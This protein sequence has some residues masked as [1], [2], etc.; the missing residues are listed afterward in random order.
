MLQRQNGRLPLYAS[1]FS[2]LR[3][4]PLRGWPTW[5]RWGQHRSGQLE[6]LHLLLQAGQSRLSTNSLC[7][8]APSIR[9]PARPVWPGMQSSN[10]ADSSTSTVSRSQCELS[11]CQVFVQKNEKRQ[12]LAASQEGRQGT[13]IWRKGLSALLLQKQPTNNKIGNLLDKEM[14]I[15]LAT[16]PCFSIC[17]YGMANTPVTTDLWQFWQMQHIEVEVSLQNNLQTQKQVEFVG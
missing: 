9:S 17:Q 3:S 2:A 16:P 8:G 1:C 7:D 5:E 13:V 10:Q 6:K 12:F 11:H 15:L 14:N 4:V